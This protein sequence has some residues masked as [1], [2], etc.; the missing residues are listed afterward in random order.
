MRL[1]LSLRSSVLSSLSPLSVCALRTLIFFR[2]FYINITHFACPHTLLTIP[3][4]ALKSIPYILSQHLCAHSRP[5]L[6]Y[7][8]CTLLLLHPPLLDNII[9]WVVKLMHVH[10]FRD[11]F[12]SFTIISSP[13][14]VCMHLFFVFS[15]STPSW[16][17]LS[18][19]WL[20]VLTIFAL[21]N[22]SCPFVIELLPWKVPFEL[23]FVFLF[24][25][26][27]IGPVGHSSSLSLNSPS[28]P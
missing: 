9:S 25:R 13:L 28:F 1:S 21:A 27:N 2:S 4:I 10:S 26:W 7:H 23:L 5:V 18:L 16:D 8:L 19:P 20:I 24:C 3:K 15:L 11:R 14:Q 12:S 6:Y 22:D 17:I